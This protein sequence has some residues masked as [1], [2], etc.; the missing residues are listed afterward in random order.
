MSA[1]TGWFVAGLVGV[2][3]AAI[4]APRLA[5]PVVVLVAIVLALRLAQKNIL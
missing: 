3:I 1:Q 2:S 5:G 4:Y